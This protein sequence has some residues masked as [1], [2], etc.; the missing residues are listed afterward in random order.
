MNSLEEDEL[1]GELSRYERAV[2]YHGA[3]WFFLILLSYYILRP[4]REQ[5]GSTY[6]LKNLSWLF[7]VT[8]LVMLAA[9]P[10]FSYLVGKFDRQKLVPLI[11]AFF[12]AGLIGF[13][14]AMSWLPDHLQ[15]WVARSFFIWIAVF[16]LFIVSFFWSVTGDMLSTE[17][18]RRI[19]GV[20]AG[21]GTVGS[22]IG[23]S[24][25]TLLVEKI[26][27]ANLLLIPTVLLLV[28]MFVYLSLERSYRRHAPPGASTVGSATGGN[29]FAGFTAV[30]KSRFLFAIALFGLLMATCG[31]TVYFQQAEIVN[32]TYS[33][34][35]VSD[36]EVEELAKTI[37]HQRAAA[38]PN[39]NQDTDEKVNVEDRE[40]AKLRLQKQASDN[41]RT[42]Y[43]ARVNFAVSIVAMFIQFV[44]ASYVMRKIGIGWT[45]AI[46]PLTFVAAITLLALS[47]TI[48]AVAVVATLGRAVEYGFCN[49]AREVLY[50]V[51]NREE[52]YKAKSFIDTVVRRGGDSAAGSVYQ[53]LRES[54]GIAMTTLTWSVI[55]FA[56]AWAGLSLFIGRENSKLAEQQ[57]TELPSPEST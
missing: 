31:T 2:L 50:T 35:P 24:A 6:G 44:L 25:A 54:A 48:A 46:L 3:I 38:I 52:R 15:I 32:N 36:D 27:V 56:I 34:M 55:P 49:P 37:A 21:C 39:D 51:V 8:F 40:T 10:L 33:N 26:G 12:I 17:Q 30:L 23:S 16:G 7:W 14:A 19:F 22:L 11:Y 29:P 18:G 45:L 1:P 43:F 42:S 4:I 41:A 28:A 53:G 47:P 13:W 57:E 9:I 5:I 20:I